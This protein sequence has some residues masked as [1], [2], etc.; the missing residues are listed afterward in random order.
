MTAM[1]KDT[2]LTFRLP[3]ETREAL[4]AAAAAERRS[5]ANLLDIIVTDWLEA[6]GHL[7]KAAPKRAR[8][9]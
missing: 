4:E 7:P 1:N 3:T 8:R 5:V 6:K 2:R 9:E